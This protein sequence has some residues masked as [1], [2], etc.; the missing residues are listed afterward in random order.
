MKAAQKKKRQEEYWSEKAIS[1]FHCHLI[2]TY[3]PF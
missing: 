2:M 3:L 1:L